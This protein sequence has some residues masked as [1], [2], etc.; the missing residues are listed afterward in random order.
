MFDTKNLQE[1]VKALS[2]GVG[3]LGETENICESAKCGSNAFIKVVASTVVHICKEIQDYLAYYTE[4]IEKGI[5][6]ACVDDEQARL[7]REVFTP[8]KNRLATLL[9][10]SSGAEPIAVQLVN[11]VAELVD[12]WNRF[13]KEDL[14]RV[15][16]SGRRTGEPRT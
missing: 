7:L 1:F 9:T 15:L 16:T 14:G 5:D 4:T 2:S 8:F 13:P 3:N 12:L 11:A 10:D 6:G